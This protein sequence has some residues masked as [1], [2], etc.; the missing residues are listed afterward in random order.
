MDRAFASG[1]KGRRFESAR[2]YHINHRKHKRYATRPEAPKPKFVSTCIQFKKSSETA[3]ILGDMDAEEDRHF[4]TFARNLCAALAAHRI[5]V[6]FRT[7]IE[8]YTPAEVDESW[9]WLAESLERVAI[10]KLEELYRVE[11]GPPGKRVQ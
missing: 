5:R 3:G 11:G 4:R 2:A 7:A 8:R 10:A 6:S 9:Y 1:A